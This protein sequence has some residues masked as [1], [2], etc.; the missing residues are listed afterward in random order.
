[1]RI[2]GI[3]VLLSG[4]FYDSQGQTLFYPEFNAP[5]T[6]YGFARN[7]DYET[8]QHFLAKFR[9]RGFTLEGIYGG[10]TKGIPTA[11]YG[12]IFDNPRSWTFDSQRHIDLSYQRALGKGWDLAARTAV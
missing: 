10:R 8:Y 2:K 4:D 3:G 12:T 1:G 6:H 11:S 7:A 9:F 5:S